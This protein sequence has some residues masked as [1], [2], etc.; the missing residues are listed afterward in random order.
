MTYRNNNLSD[1]KTGVVTSPRDQFRRRPACCLSGVR[2]EGGV[3]LSQAFVRNVGTCRLDAKGEAVSGSPTK[4]SVPM[5]GTGA[6]QPVV[7]MRS[8]KAD[9]AKGLR[10]PALFV[11]QPETGRSQ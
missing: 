2:Y 5:R 9:G 7:A 1:V 3:I 4:A 8:V 11:G 10:H 6:E